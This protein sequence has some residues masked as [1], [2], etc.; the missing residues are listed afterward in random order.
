MNQKNT[1]MKCTKFCGK[2]NA[3]FFLGRAPL[4]KLRTLLVQPCD[5]DEEKDD[6]FFFM[7]AD[8]A[9]C[10]KNTVSGHVA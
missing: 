4:Q 6:Q 3:D 9:T 7:N 10:F 1:T 5:E 8:Y 2:E